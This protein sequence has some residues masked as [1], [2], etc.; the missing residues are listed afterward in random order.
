MTNRERISVSVYPGDLRRLAD[1]AEH[2]RGGED[3]PRVSQAEAV[4]RAIMAEW[5]RARQR[6]VV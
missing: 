2:Y 1:L 3:E 6:E 5:Q 4:R